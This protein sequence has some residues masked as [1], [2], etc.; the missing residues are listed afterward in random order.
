MASGRQRVEVVA[1]ALSLLAYGYFA[2]R[3]LGSKGIS[4]DEH[5]EAQGMIDSLRHDYSLFVGRESSYQ[6]IVE[7]L[8]YHGVI[9][10]VP[11][12]LLWLIANPSQLHEVFN[13]SIALGL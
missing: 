12:L 3:F 10:K 6:A 13:A 2:L 9:N 8:E 4:F 5:L 7:N 11:G 1:L